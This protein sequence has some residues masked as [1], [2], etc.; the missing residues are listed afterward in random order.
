MR[1]GELL[2]VVIVVPTHPDA[3]LHN[4]AK[5]HRAPRLHERT[6]SAWADVARRQ[7]ASCWLRCRK[8]DGRIKSGAF[9]A[10]WNS[11]CRRQILRN[12]EA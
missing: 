3:P 5:P 12:Q 1:A 7:S 8:A 4:N 10:R 6:F 9:A 2:R 11:N